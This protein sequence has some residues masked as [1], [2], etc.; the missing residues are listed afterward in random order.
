MLAL[1]SEG[2][3]SRLLSSVGTQVING[4][5]SRNLSLLMLV[6]GILPGWWPESLLYFVTDHKTSLSVLYLQHTVYGMH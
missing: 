2:T 6:G 1:Q 5:K 4:L 3:V